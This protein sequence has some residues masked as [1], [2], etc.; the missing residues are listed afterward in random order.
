MTTVT[1]RGAGIFGLS[2]AWFCLKAGARVRV[3]DPAGVAAGASGG[4]VGALSPHSPDRWSE[5]KAF[6][7]RSLVAARTFWPEVDAVTGLRSGYGPVP[8]VRPLPDADA[9]ARAR[10][11]ARE[12]ARNWGEAGAWTL[13]EADD[14]APSATGLAVRDTLSARLHPARATLSLAEAL[15]RCGV[16][17][18]PEAR[19]EGAV[20]WAAGHAGLADLSRR[21]AREAGRGIK[22][23]AATLGFDARGFPQV[24]ADGIYI[25]PHEDAT[26]GVGSTTERD[27]TTPEP[28]AQLDEV[29]TRARA[30]CPALAGAP[31]LRRWAGIR[32]RA[33]SRAPMLGTWPDRPGHY[34]ANGGFKIGFGVAVEVGRLMADLVV[35]NR[36][37]IP[38]PFRVEASL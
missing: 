32:P 24:Q 38:T 10:E 6:Q 3:V 29:I 13:V 19:D 20:V 30:I 12:A 35:R 18:V 1:V 27:W 7:L 28:D 11:L 5:V 33:R 14:W 37:A 21:R 36:D 15:R 31:V 25:V 26:V 34:V 4:L 22:G 16:E 23:Q 17:I 9:V 8:R 2:V